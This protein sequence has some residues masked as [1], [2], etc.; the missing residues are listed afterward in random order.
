MVL[1]IRFY[2]YKSRISE[3]LPTTKEALLCIQTVYL[4][5]KK[6]GKKAEII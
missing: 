5:Q 4:S 6:I 3:S 1:C 2:I